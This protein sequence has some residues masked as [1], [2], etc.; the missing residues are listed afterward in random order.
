MSDP[1]IRTTARMDDHARGQRAMQ[2]RAAHAV[3]V[4][5]ADATP[6]DREILVSLIDAIMRLEVEPDELGVNH[7]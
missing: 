3:M 7:V 6:H 1:I 2:H 4:S 5:K